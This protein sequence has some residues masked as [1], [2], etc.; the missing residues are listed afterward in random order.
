[1]NGKVAALEQANAQL[2]R[3]VS[4]LQVK[5]SQAQGNASAQELQQL[6]ERVAQLDIQREKDKQ[7]I[8]EQLSKELAAMARSRAASSASSSSSGGSDVGYEHKVEAGQTLSDIARAYKT[9]V[10]AIKKANNLTS[11]N[12]RVGQVLFIPKPR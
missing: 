12:I 3:E 8:L 1:L 6:R 11:D 10:S 7:A 2:Q 9:T 5:L 4:D